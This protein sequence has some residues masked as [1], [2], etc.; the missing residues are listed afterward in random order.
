VSAQKKLFSDLICD[1]LKLEE[2]NEELFERYLY[3][4]SIPDPDLLIRTSGECR[5]SNFL[6]WQLAYTELYFTKTL[7]PD[8]NITCLRRAIKNYNKRERRYGLSK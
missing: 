6:L 1:K 2:L 5:I 4:A 7:W 3:T 8:F